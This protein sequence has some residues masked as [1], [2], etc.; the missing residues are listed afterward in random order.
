MIVAVQKG[1][2]Q[3]R[4]HKNRGTHGQTDALPGGVA[5]GPVRVT[6]LYAI[7]PGSPRR[8]RSAARNG[9]NEE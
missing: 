4:Q 7:F 9:F 5:E 2:G 3:S 8:K 1:D 6:H